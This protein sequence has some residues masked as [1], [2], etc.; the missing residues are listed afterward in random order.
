MSIFKFF[1]SIAAFS[2]NLSVDPYETTV[3]S[4]PFFKI[5]AFPNKTVNSERLVGSLSF[6]LYPFK[7]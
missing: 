4:K 6:N 5:S 3:I 1:N 2:T 7:D